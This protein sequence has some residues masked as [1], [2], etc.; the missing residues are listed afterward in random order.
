MG[1]ILRAKVKANY[2]D[3]KKLRG[4]FFGRGDS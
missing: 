1:T 3:N 4:T 2:I